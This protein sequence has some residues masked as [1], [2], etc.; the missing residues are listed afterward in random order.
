VLHYAAVKK[1]R[2]VV[3]Q[4]VNAQRPELVYIISQQA[5]AAC[6]EAHA[7]IG[8]ET[9][10]SSP[11]SFA[12]SSDTVSVNP[13]SLRR[14][15]RQTLVLDAV[16]VCKLVRERSPEHGA[17][18][19][20]FPGGAESVKCYVQAPRDGRGTTGGRDLDGRDAGDRA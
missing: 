13:A 5:W 8:R 15:E 2:A 18:G 17:D 4:R 1:L 11:R 10:S 6:A 19:E 9:L 12:S 3:E 20:V 7:C 14:L 16:H